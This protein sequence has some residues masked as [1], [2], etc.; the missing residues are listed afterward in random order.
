M[1]SLSF[2]NKLFSKLY[3]FANKRLIVA[4]SGGKDSTALLHYLAVKRHLFNYSLFPVYINHNLRKD[5][6]QEIKKCSAFCEQLGLDLI[7]YN[8]DVYK[9]VNNEKMSI[10]EAARKLRYAELFRAL[11][12]FNCDYILLAHTYNDLIENFF[13]KIMRGT[14]IFSLKGFNASP[15]LKR[16]LLDISTE[17]VIEYNNAYYLEYIFDESNNDDRFLRNWVR[18]NIVAKILEKNRSFLKNISYIQEES[19][20]ISDY[21][22]KKIDV[23]YLALKDYIRI[24]KK[25]FLKLE[26]VERLFFL[27]RVM[28]IQI[29]RSII[30]EIN[31]I[32]DLKNSKR[33]SLP[34]NYIFEVT[35][36]NI[37][38][39]KKDLIKAFKIIKGKG[40]DCIKIEH[41]RKI[42][43]FD[44]TLSK[45]VLSIRNRK[46]GD[47]LNRKKLKDIFIDKKIDL[48]KRD[49]SI[50]VER[51]N[52]IVYVE[53]IYKD[54]N[55]SIKVYNEDERLCVS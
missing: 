41:L 38:I 5:I 25:D 47:R 12:N 34:N 4:Y 11:E 6:E 10:E 53:H 31:K 28:P 13:I 26:K 22:S 1:M 23:D 48:F 37:Y 27:S 54:K 44:D 45:E 19:K 8:I 51:N 36:D 2:D 49:T 39:F 29:S 43:F 24:N 50:I 15:V 35:Y 40:S 21:I 52:N 33:L 3:N 17:E 55:Y 42:V 14:S 30:D 7:I 46:K 16:P 9:L 20:L 32:I 18:H